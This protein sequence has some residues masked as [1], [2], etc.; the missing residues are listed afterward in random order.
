MQ[1]FSWH[2]RLMALSVGSL[3]FVACSSAAPPTAQ[4][5][6]SFTATEGPR[7][8]STTAPAAHGRSPS[9]SSWTSRTRCP[10]SPG[11]RPARSGVPARSFGALSSPLPPRRIP[12]RRTACSR[13]GTFPRSSPPPP[14]RPPVGDGAFGGQLRSGR[15]MHEWVSLG[16]PLRR[17][18]WCDQRSG[19]RCRA[20]EFA[21]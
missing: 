6:A 5:A 12:P 3:L 17:A 4:P 15:F 9:V 7:P 18:T 20:H 11:S 8:A 19:K 2:R 16:A 1:P 21:L 10:S 13:D 14:V